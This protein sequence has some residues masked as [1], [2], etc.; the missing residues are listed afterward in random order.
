MLRIR[1]EQ[2]DL[3]DAHMMRK[4]EQRVVQ[5]IKR[6]FPKW[7]EQEGEEK[8]RLLVQAG[9]RKAEGYGITEDDDVERFILLLV[10]Y[11]LAFE[12]KPERLE[13]RA[14]LEDQDLPADAK[15]A[16]VREELD[17]EGNVPGGTGSLGV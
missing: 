9:V 16:M 3:L 15:V 7:Y 10:P 1:K 6:T 11:G 13:C 17:S 14:I 4:Y 12:K 5:K 8:T 2:M